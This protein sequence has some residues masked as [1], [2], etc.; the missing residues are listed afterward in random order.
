MTAGCALSLAAGAEGPVA[1]LVGNL[2][3]A[4]TVCQLATTGTARR[5]ELGPWLRVWQEQQS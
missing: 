1:A 3:A 2:V 4:I 5:E